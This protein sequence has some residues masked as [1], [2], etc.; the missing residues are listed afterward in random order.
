MR[1]CVC[2]RDGEQETGEVNNDL[3]LSFS[4]FSPHRMSLE[5]ERERER[6][7]ERSQKERNGKIFMLERK[8]NL[9]ITD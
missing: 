1:V 9:F 2:V 6:E 5:G 4:L 7:R 3:S 8:L